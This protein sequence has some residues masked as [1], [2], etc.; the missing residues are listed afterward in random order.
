M[1]SN[2]RSHY[3]GHQLPRIDVDDGEGESDV[4]LADHGQA[5]SPPGVRAFWLIIILVE[6]EEM[7]I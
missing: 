1:V 7:I 3:G 5:D 6:M 2:L 4:E